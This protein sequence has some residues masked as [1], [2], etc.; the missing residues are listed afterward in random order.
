VADSQFRGELVAATGEISCLSA[1]RNTAAIGE[2]LMAA[3]S[4]E[5]GTSC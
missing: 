3:D 1:G 2:D 5:R 4:E